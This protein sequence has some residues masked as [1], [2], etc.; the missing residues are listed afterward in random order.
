MP[1]HWRAPLGI[2]TTQSESS[3]VQCRGHLTPGRTLQALACPT[4]PRWISDI[5][6][7]HLIPWTLRQAGPFHLWG[8]PPPFRVHT[9]LEQ[10]RTGSKAAG[11]EHP[12]GNSV[13][14]SPKSQLAGAAGT[15]HLAQKCAALEP[16]RD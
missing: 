1:A 16:G 3:A 8:Q 15:S 10:A 11:E 4:T 5:P 7:S 12:P 2:A 9:A 6:H 13:G 14:D